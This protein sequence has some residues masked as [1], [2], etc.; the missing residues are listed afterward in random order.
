MLLDEG[1]LDSFL[2][3]LKQCPMGADREPETWM[4]RGVAKEKSGDWDG[5]ARMFRR[6]IELNP[7]VPK[8]YYRL[9]VAELRLG[10]D[11]SAAAH[12]QRTKVMNDAR[13]QLPAAYAAFFRAKTAEKSDSQS[14]DAVKK[15]LASLCETL[16]WL[17]LAQGWNRLVL[18]P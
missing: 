17:R 3:V 4:Y 6:A 18:S 16:G 11:E 14:M 9:S 15:R 8:Y 5:A 7:S 10:L 13:A 2:T 1:E 12:R